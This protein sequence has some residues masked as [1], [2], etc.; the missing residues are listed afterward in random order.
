VTSTGSLARFAKMKAFDEAAAYKSISTGLLQIMGS[1]AVEYGYAD[2][3]VD[4]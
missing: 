4:V 3:K 2:A 1:N